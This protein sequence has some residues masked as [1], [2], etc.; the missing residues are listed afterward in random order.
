MGAAAFVM[1]SYLGKHYWQIALIGF[2][3]AIIFYACVALAVYI[4]SRQYLKLEV[5]IEEGI[6]GSPMEKIGF[7][8]GVPLV[9]AIVVL[10]LLMSLFW[11]DVMIA[12][13]FMIIAFLSTWLIGRAIRP[14]SKRESGRLFVRYFVEGITKG[15]QTTAEITIM[16]ACIGIIVAVLIQTGLAQ[17][18][19]FGIVEI[20][21]GNREILILLVGGLCTLFGMVATTVA[22]YILTVTLA[23]PVLLDMGIPLLS[24][25]FAVFYFSMMGLITPPVAPCCAV[26]SGIAKAGFLEICWAAIKI[27]FVMLLLPF[28][29]F[30]HPDLVHLSKSTVKEFFLTG[31]GAGCLILGVNLRL[32]GFSGMLKRVAYIAVGLMTLFPNPTAG[33]LGMVLCGLFLVWELY[34]LRDK[35][36]SSLPKP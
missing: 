4:Y 23:A 21:G 7:G 10:V 29:F 15:A 3:P 18:L 34:R 9:S 19:S 31:L 6:P 20:A 17:K 11:L 24:T 35:G 36:P 5:G 22:A 12:G 27:G 13:F 28:V 16:M 33:Y 14:D 8:D 32:R 30:Y 2:L 26:A 1:A 25:H